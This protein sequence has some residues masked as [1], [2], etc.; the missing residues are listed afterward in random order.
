MRKV[1][2]GII[3]TILIALP[4]SAQ[5]ADQIVASYIKTIGGMEKIQAVKSMRQTGKFSGGGGF[6]AMIVN[7]NKRPN[8][9]RQEFSLQGLTAVNAYDG[10]TGWK[11][12][13]FSGKKDAESLG[14]EEMKQIIEDS[15]FDGPLINYA[16]K[17]IRVELVGKEEY[18]GS[19]V[20]KLKVT[21]A[22]GTVKYYFMDTDYFVPI[23]IETK[24][25]NRGTEFEFETVLGDYKE[26]GGVYYPFS[27]ET[28]LKGSPNKSTVTVEK[29]DI[30][31][32]LDDKNFALPAP[33]EKSPK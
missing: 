5:T 29:I 32:T 10:K 1:L 16:A 3:A 31:V 9:V 20:Y 4:V 14:E 15:D 7:E 19:D 18:E 8:L 6:E 24:Q 13:P 2:L 27:V 25:I 26:V 21:L 17:G 22:N 23:K 12:N 30:N 11:I 33:K 28:G